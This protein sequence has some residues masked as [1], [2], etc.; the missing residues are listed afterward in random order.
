MLSRL[1]LSALTEEERAAIPRI[2]AKLMKA[3]AAEA[4]KAPPLRRTLTIVGVVREM[5]PG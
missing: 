1:D 5:E 3:R 2:A 4:G